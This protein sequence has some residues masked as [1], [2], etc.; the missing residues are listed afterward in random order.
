LSQSLVI[1]KNRAAL[2]LKKKDNAEHAFEQLEEITQSATE[3]IDEAKEIIHNLRPIQLDRL[4]LT[5][6][7][8]A[9]LRRVAETHEIR[10][11]TD[12]ETIDN[13]FSK[14]AESSVYRILQE[15]IN[16]VV[17]HSAATEAA[18][19]IKRGANR[20]EIL[21]KDNGKGFAIDS[22]NNGAERGSFG[23]TGIKERARL[24]GGEAFVESSIGKGTTVQIVLPIAVQDEI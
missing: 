13:L 12:I 7:I 5:K 18:V 2:S 9:M 14:D 19:K 10:F 15:S 8:S 6:A 24:L 22:M 17:R 16:N 21:I 1:I 23:L 3:A 20:I 11:Q 4:G